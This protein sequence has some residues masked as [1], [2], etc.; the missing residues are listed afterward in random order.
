MFSACISVPEHVQNM[1]TR[2]RLSQARLEL[3]RLLFPGRSFLPFASPMIACGDPIWPGA[4][5]RA[6]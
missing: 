6:A 4:A 1:Y 5:Q 2:H 3:L